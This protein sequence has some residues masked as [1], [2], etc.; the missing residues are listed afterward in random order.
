MCNTWSLDTSGGEDDGGVN[1]SDYEGFSP[2]CFKVI[3]DSERY[4]DSMVVEG[5][6]MT[7]NLHMVHPSPLAHGYILYN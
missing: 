5:R 4:K 7:L 6:C 3:V 1:S 2:F